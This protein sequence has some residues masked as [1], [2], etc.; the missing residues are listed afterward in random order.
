MAFERLC[1]STD[2]S[3]ERTDLKR[4]ISEAV[5]AAPGNVELLWSRWFLDAGR[6]TGLKIDQFTAT[7]ESACDLAASGMALLT[8]DV[9]S[10]KFLLL[11][12][13]DRGR[14][15]SAWCDAEVTAPKISPDE[16]VRVLADNNPDR[17]LHWIAVGAS[18]LYHDENSSGQSTPPL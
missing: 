14:V 15:Q 6:A 12:R 4:A 7:V 8:W 9:A 2:S 1:R 3:L 5:A 10:Q 16:L 18:S 13:D 17:S 11:Q